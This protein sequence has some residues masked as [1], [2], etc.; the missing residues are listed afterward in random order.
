MKIF[1]YAWM[2]VAGIT[3]LALLLAGQDFLSGPLVQTPLLYIFPIGLA[4]WFL[5]ERWGILFALGLS[6]ARAY[7]TWH[8]WDD[9][10]PTGPVLV[11]LGLRSAVYILIAALVD[12]H[13][14]LHRL[15]A[16][17]LDL[18]L[19]HLPVGLGICDAKGKSSPSHP[20]LHGHAEG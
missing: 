17:R 1:Q 13:S 14:R 20:E 7:F 5:G 8:F 2:R 6:G 11:N 15:Q 18:I 4:A 10:V 16:R 3:L 9:V 12:R 19:E